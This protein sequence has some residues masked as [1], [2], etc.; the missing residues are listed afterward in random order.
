[1][2]TEAAPLDEE[3]KLFLMKPGFALLK[4][5]PSQIQARKVM[6]V[7]DVIS[8]H[9]PDEECIGEQMEPSWEENPS[10]GLPLK[11]LMQD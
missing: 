8:S 1:M 5:F 11:G 9:S 3:L 10:L 4:Y 2:P 6:T 7:L